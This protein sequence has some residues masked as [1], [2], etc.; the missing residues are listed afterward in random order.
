MTAWREL[1]SWSKAG[2]LAC[3]AFLMMIPDYS[4]AA[5]CEEAHPAES[6]PSALASLRS[7]SSWL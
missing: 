7:A 4:E 5:G 2:I 1:S 6:A 3:V